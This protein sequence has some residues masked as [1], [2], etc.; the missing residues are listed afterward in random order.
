MSKGR[1]DNDDIV[2]DLRGKGKRKDA[3][4][5]GGLFQTH[6]DPNRTKRL[7]AK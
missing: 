5:D 1:H 6:D 3:S 4:V 2:D 7:N